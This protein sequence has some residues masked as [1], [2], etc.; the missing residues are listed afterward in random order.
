QGSQALGML[1]TLGQM[2]TIVRQT[3]A[4][5]S[6]VLHLDL[7]HLMQEGPSDELN[8]TH[9]TQPALLAAEVAIW[10]LWQAQ[11]GPTPVMMAGHSLGE[12][13]ALVCSE[14][15]TYP[16]AV[17]LVANRGRLMQEAVAPGQGA[18]AA[19][20]GLD[21]QEVRAACTEA[22]A[23]EI[24]QAANFNAPGQV[25][26]S[27]HTRAVERACK[28]AKTAG[29]RRTLSIP[30]SVPSHCDLMQPAA[31]KLAAYLNNIPIQA[32]KI[33]VIH[34]VSVVCAEDPVF[35]RSQLEAQIHSPV[36]WVETIKFMSSD[37]IKAFVEMGPGKVL[38]GLNKRILPDLP[39]WPV[40]DPQT[41][42]QAL[43]DL[44]NYGQ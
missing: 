25:V 8:A 5:A 20:L 38:T 6:E 19:I 18:M 12:Y 3:I 28:L 9:N 13:S 1:K 11:N 33:S 23:G 27:G 32:P 44:S 37:G 42:D 17:A 29:A 39:V 16:E 15:I 36:R 14:S 30:V 21:D 2:Y 31:V 43:K 34:N 10:R 40:F 7:W 35:I 26:I 24:V 41:L 22:A 4:E